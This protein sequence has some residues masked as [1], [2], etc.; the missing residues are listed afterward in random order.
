MSPCM[1]NGHCSKRYPRSF[2]DETQTGADSYPLYRRRTPQNGGFTGKIN[3]RC[4]SGY[5]EIEIDNR[6]VV[7]YNPF[8][9]RVFQAHINVELCSSV[10][11][12]KYICKYIHKGSDQ[13]VF[14]LKKS[15]TSI[16]EVT[17]FQL[18]RYISSNEAV[19]RI[20]G[21]PIHEREPTVVHLTV[22]LENGQ[23]VYFKPDNLLHKVNSPPATTLTAFFELCQNDPFAKTLLYCDVPQYYTWNYSKKKFI[24]RKQGKAVEGHPEIRSCAALGRV[25]TV[26]PS[27]DECFFLRLLLHVQHGPTSFLD[28]KNVNGQMCKTFREAC[29]RQGLLENDKHWDT[30]LEEASATKSPK[31]L[32]HLFCLLLTS[33]SMSNPLNLWEKYKTSM[34]EDFQIRRQTTFNVDLNSNQESFNQTLC[35]LE[36][37]I[38]SINGKLLREYGLPS[39]DRDLA[40]CSE[41]VRETNYNVAELAEYVSINEPLLLPEQKLAYETVLQRVRQN[42]GGILF[43]DAPGGTGKTFVLNLILAK[44]RQQQKLAIAVA[45]SG[46]AATLLTGGRTAHSTFK[47]PLNIPHSDVPI[48]NISK[49]SEKGKLLKQCAIIIWDECTMAHKKALEALGR[50]LQDL[51]SNKAV[52]GGVVLVLAGDFR[53]TLPVIPRSTMADELNA[54]LK[55]SYLWNDITELKLKQNMRAKLSGDSSANRF[56]LQ[57]LDVGNGKIKQDKITGLIEFSKDFCKLVRTCDELK[58][59]V[60]PNLEAN[61]KNH[62][63]LCERVILAPKNELVFKLNIEIQNLLPGDTRIYKS[64]DTVLDPD[65]AVHY[66][67]EFLNSLQPSGMPLHELT[68]KVGSPIILLRNLDPPKLCNG[69]RLSIKKMYSHIIEATIMNGS[70]KGEDVFIP[71]IPLIPT[72]LPFDFKR[73][74]FPV[75]LAFAMTVNKAQG[76]SMSVVGVNLETPCFPHGQLYVACSRVGNP[77]NLFI[78]TTEGKTKNIVYQKALL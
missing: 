37:H 31:K 45:S 42:E 49:Q 78:L 55:A 15:G 30:A 16:D 12:I 27:N 64:V 32:R 8:L 73:L 65:Q 36:E 70:G 75:Q 72:D 25:Y 2:L 56:A 63:W 26:H 6:W 38:A 52:M 71:R 60:Y 67:T 62:Q 33:C 74:Q 53:Q 18:G 68:L 3:T 46:I 5:Q 7:P 19:W 4:A 47:L 9:C 29:E 50:T 61:F 28:L 57:L 58:D 77:N 69:T 17:A 22:H 1:V 21:M 40:A 10:K 35:A 24:R 51:R 54:C 39:P 76:Q 13:A 41:I 66:P 59:S 20:L 34:S 44:V 43:I 23:R 48:C 14:E 11:S